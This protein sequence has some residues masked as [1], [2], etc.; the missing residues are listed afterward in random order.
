MRITGVGSGELCQIVDIYEPENQSKGGPYY[1]LPKPTMP[2]VFKVLITL[3]LIAFLYN[4]V[5][6]AIVK[7]RSRG[8]D[9]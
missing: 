7:S 5:R 9:L 6:A 2:S 8:D 3:I 1:G 4:L